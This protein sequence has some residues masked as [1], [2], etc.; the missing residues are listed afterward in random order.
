[1]D[2]NIT[3]KRPRVGLTQS[4]MRSL[5][6]F[7]LNKEDS[8]SSAMEQSSKKETPLST[9]AQPAYGTPTLMDQSLLST[10]M[11]KCTA[12]FAYSELLHKYLMSL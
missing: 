9:L 10:K 6:L 3:R 8:N 7:T 12:S 5:R 4:A 11:N 1:M 2:S